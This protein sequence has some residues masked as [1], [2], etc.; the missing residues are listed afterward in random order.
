MDHTLQ[1]YLMAISV[2][3]G[4]AIWIRRAWAATVPLAFGACAGP[5]E[6]MDKGKHSYQS[7]DKGGRRPRSPPCA[8]RWPTSRRS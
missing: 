2:Q 3:I 8:S 4:A 7:A 5:I 1:R 6:P